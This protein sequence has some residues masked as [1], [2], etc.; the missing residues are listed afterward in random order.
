[1]AREQSTE[2]TP[3][4]TDAT[5]DASCV[6]YAS[7]MVM[8]SV[9]MIAFACGFVTYNQWMMTPS[10]FPFAVP[11]VLV[12]QGF[13]CVFSVVLLFLKP[14]LFPAITSPTAKVPLDAGFVLKGL[15]PIAMAFSTSLVLS[16]VA[17]LHLE[18]SFMQFIRE[19]N[20]ITVFFFS[21]MAGLEKWSGQKLFLIMLASVGLT[22][23]VT[24]ET[25][26]E[27]RGFMIQLVAVMCESFRIVLQGTLL[28]EGGHR[29]DVLSYVTITAPLC[30][31]FLVL[32]MGVINFLPGGLEGR[33]MTLPTGSVVW[34][35]WPHLVANS[36]V[37]FGMNVSIALLIKN[38]SPMCYIFSQLTKDIVMVVVSV[39]FLKAW[40][41]GM[42]T[43]GF[44]FQLI[45]IFLWA[46]SQIFAR[47]FAGG[48]ICGL[49][50]VLS[51]ALGMRGQNRAEKA[52]ENCA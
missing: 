12:Q 2:V 35:W 21:L 36:C 37:A 51:D 29:L 18:V 17:Y 9:V 25:H 14:S 38:T 50:F 40:V 48:F 24:G 45:A 42:Q 8:C 46:L 34:S 49:R 11:L 10:R 32:S 26:F 23:A 39:V 31:V 6:V 15:F 16:N 3:F 7:R 19:T 22:L 28:S 47:Q 44:T 4:A 41:T 1:M 30:F 5:N 43:I 52:A 27:F 33:G 13:S 20:V